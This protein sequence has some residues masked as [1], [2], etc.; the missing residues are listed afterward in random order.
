MKDKWDVNE[1]V[2]MLIQEE[3][4][5]KSSMSHYVNVVQGVGKALKPKA[6]NFK[7]KGYP[8]GDGSDSHFFK[9]KGHF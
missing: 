3:N 1:L 5:L 2:G 6:K 9:K 7:K 4:R 8:N